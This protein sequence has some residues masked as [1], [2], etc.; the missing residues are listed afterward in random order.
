MLCSVVIQSNSPRIELNVLYRQCSAVLVQWGGNATSVA[1]GWWDEVDR[2]HEWEAVER[3]LITHNA[4]VVWNIVQVDYF[5][6]NTLH[7]TVDNFEA[8]R[9]SIQ[10]DWLI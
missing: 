6:T 1:A 9:N 10:H 5:V 7:F 3:D 4:A 2:V 8:R